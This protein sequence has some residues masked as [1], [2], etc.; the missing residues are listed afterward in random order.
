MPVRFQ[1]ACMEQLS[2]MPDTFKASDWQ[3]LVNGL[4]ENLNE[5]EVP[6]ELTFKGQ[7]FEHMEAYCTG[8]IQAQSAEEIILGKPYTREGFTFFRLDSR[9]NVEDKNTQ[10]LV[11]EI[12]RLFMYGVAGHTLSQKIKKNPKIAFIN[13]YI[14]PLQNLT[15]NTKNP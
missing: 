12:L 8:R 15:I 5:I 1:R 13:V 4:M 7:F 3:I 11:N 10:E 2:F 14:Y 6:D 9:Q